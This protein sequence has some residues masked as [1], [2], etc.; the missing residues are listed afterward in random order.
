MKV[1]L[2]SSSSG[3]HIYPCLEVGNYLEEQGIEV[4]YLGFKNQMEEEILHSKKLITLNSKNSFNKIIKRP[5]EIITLIKEINK[6]KKEEFDIFIGFGGFITLIAIF[7]KGKKPLFIHEQNIEL[8]DSNKLA[9]KYSEKVFYSFET[10]DKKGKVVGNPR[11][12]KIRK[13]TFKYKNKFNILFIFGSLGSSSLIDKLLLIDEK[14]DN[15]HQYTLVTG[16]KLYL[17]YKNRFKQ[18]IIKEY[19]NLNKELDYFD[20]IFSRGGATTLYEI[21]KSNTYCISIPSPYVKNNHQEKNVDYLVEKGLIEKIK[22]KDFSLQS[23]NNNILKFIDY[24]YA[25]SR[26]C[27]MNKYNTYNSSELIY[28]EIIKYVKN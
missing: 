20:I 1:L 27:N 26:F 25:L 3:G 23:I 8:G 15:A 28:Q 4:N 5:K 14:L 7:I 12:D 22:E 6:I 11:G 10:N 24:D 16:S 19:I 17:K 2:L 18:I 13:K 21:I 9:R